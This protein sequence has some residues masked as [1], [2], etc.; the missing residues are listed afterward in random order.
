[1]RAEPLYSDAHPEYVDEEAPPVQAPETELSLPA[2]DVPAAADTS[3]PAEAMITQAY[4]EKALF[5][6]VIL[7][8]VLYLV[9]RR[10]AAY[11]KVDEKSMA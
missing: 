11:E 2:K 10:R 8:V 9:R 1:M 5:F 3:A 7:A 4:M 6:L